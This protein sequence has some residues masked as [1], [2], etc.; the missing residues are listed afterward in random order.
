MFE[1]E[2]SK[3]PVKNSFRQDVN[4]FQA[5]ISQTQIF[6]FVY[7]KPPHQNNNISMKFNDSLIKLSCIAFQYNCF[8]IWKFYSFVNKRQKRTQSN[9][10]SNYI[11]ECFTG[12]RNESFF[13]KHFGIQFIDVYYLKAYHYIELKQYNILSN[14]KNMKQMLY[15]SSNKVSFHIR[16]FEIGLQKV[17]ILLIREILVCHLVKVG[18]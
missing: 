4:E 16:I 11:D 17:I 3:K 9:R 18:L 12:S 13:K 2:T 14:N 1:Y 15:T 6:S 10:T 7:Q 8:I 5:F